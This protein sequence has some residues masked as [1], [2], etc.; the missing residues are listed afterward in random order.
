[1]R[2]ISLQGCNYFTA[3]LP[4]LHV[5]STVSYYGFVRINGFRLCFCQCLHRCRVNV[6]FEHHYITRLVVNSFN[7][8]SAQERQEDISSSIATE[9]AV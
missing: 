9:A 6:T 2:Y 8:L 3:R 4:L 7:L 5:Y 1:M